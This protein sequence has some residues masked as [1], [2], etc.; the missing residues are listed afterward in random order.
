M[1]VNTAKKIT[2]E[3][4]TGCFP[5]KANVTDAAYDLYTSK[6]VDLKENTRIKIPL[7]F[8]VSLPPGSCLSIQPRSGQSVSGL[9]VQAMAPVWLGAGFKETTIN[10]D[11]ILGLVD[12]NYGK[13]VHA[14]VRVGRFSLKQRF[15]SLLGYRF[16]LERFSRICQG[17]FSSVPNVSLTRGIVV[18]TRSGFG[19]TGTR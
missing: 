2:I 19:S 17:R 12:A 14:I 3:A 8:K 1:K 6:A 10:A 16:H 7:G 11:V 13:E 15:M 18:G 4:E 5:F 9:V